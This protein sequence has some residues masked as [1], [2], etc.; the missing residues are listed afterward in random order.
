[1]GNVGFKSVLKVVI[2]IIAFTVVIA[3]VW[4]IF[5]LLYTM[6]EERGQPPVLWILL[7]FAIGPLAHLALW[8]FFDIVKGDLSSD[9]NSN[10]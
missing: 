8:L 6:P 10:E 4:A 2:G 3:I 9:R 7:F 5:S 1:L